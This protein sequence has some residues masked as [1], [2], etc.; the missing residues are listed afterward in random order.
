VTRSQTLV[1][2]TAH[3]L[4]IVFWF[5]LASAMSR[6]YAVAD[7][8]LSLNDIACLLAKV[9][10][11]GLPELGLNDLAQAPRL[12]LNL[13]ALVLKQ[14]S[15]QTEGVGEKRDED[16]TGEVVDFFSGHQGADAHGGAR[17]VVEANHGVVDLLANT[18]ASGGIR[19]LRN[20]RRHSPSHAV[21]VSLV[22]FPRTQPQLRQNLQQWRA[23]TW[24]ASREE[25]CEPVS[26]MLE[27]CQE[28]SAHQHCEEVTCCLRDLMTT[29]VA[30]THVRAR[31]PPPPP[32]RR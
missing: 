22:V 14:L 31:D 4:S 1:V 28:C 32:T 29:V 2:F 15:K 8:R 19:E 6:N 11:K 24:A 23:Q 3:P 26:G 7:A 27:V 9:S 10:I 21:E 12:R 30:T 18:H 13:R 16:G 17:G 5:S 25:G 20:A